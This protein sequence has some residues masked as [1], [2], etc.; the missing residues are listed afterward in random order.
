MEQQQSYSTVN[1]PAFSAPVRKSATPTSVIVGAM[2]SGPM[3][4]RRTPTRP[5]KPSTTWNR[6]DNNMAP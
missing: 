6:D 3:K 2:A 5:V 1:L 4:R